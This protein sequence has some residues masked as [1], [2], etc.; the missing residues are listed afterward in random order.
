MLGYGL[1]IRLVVIFIMGEGGGRGI[2]FVFSF[3]WRRE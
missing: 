2:C 3:N 1:Y